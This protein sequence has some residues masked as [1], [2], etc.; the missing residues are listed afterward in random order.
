MTVQFNIS[1]EDFINFNIDHFSKA[2]SARA[3]RLRI[4]FGCP[5]VFFIITFMLDRFTITATNLISTAAVLLVWSTYLYKKVYER[6]IRQN[7]IKYIDAGN[8][9]DIIGRQ[10]ITLLDT[11]MEESNNTHVQQI[12]YS[13]IESILSGHDLYYIYTGNR[14]AVIIPYSA[15]ENETERRE[16]ISIL[17]G[18]TG[19]DVS[20]LEKI[21]GR[22]TI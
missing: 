16:F 1:K 19:I 14:K 3:A 4:M 13:L 9:N 22:K 5:L 15:F 20:S 21:K 12:E 11:G 6:T 8:A 18:K 2:K 10:K 7:V 17:S